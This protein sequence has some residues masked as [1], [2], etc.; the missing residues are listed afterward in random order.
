MISIMPIKLLFLSILK[1]MK[2]LFLIYKD[3]I[4]YTF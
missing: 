3:L 1:K 2:F 4:D